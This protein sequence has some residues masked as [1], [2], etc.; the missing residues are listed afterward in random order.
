MAQIFDLINY[1]PCEQIHKFV[2]KPRSSCDERER[3]PSRTD[4]GSKSA[5]NG[6]ITFAMVLSLFTANISSRGSGFNSG[7]SSAHANWVEPVKRIGTTVRALV[8]KRADK[9]GAVVVARLGHGEL[10]LDTENIHSFIDWLWRAQYYA[11]FPVRVDWLVRW[12]ETGHG[13]GLRFGRN[14]F[15]MVFVICNFCGVLIESNSF[16]QFMAGSAFS[17]RGWSSR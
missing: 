2:A 7:A 10:A 1:R 9:E 4:T 8:G 6:V 17:R 3:E 13:T 15:Q 11:F 5:R 16:E 12:W 14:D